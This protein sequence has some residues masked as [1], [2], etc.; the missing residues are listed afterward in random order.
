MWA[1][2]LTSCRCCPRVGVFVSQHTLYKST[3]ISLKLSDAVDSVTHANSGI[4]AECDTWCDTN[5]NGG[6]RLADWYK[7]PR[8]IDRQ[9]EVCCV[10]DGLLRN[11]IGSAPIPISF[12]SIL[13]SIKGRFDGLRVKNSHFKPMLNPL[14]PSYDFLQSQQAFCRQYI[15]ATTISCLPK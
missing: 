5:I 13:E 12:H 2:I 7:F 15:S 6:Y 11:T 4:H 1:N 3:G 10:F 9:I 14:H 8:M